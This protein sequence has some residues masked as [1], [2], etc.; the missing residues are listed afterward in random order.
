M[1]SQRL[2]VNDT[3]KNG[4]LIVSLSLLSHVSSFT[5]DHWTKV[6]SRS[7][8]HKMNLN[9]NEGKSGIFDM[10]RNFDDVMED[11]FFKRMGNGE[12]FYGK[13]KYNPSG[14]VEGKYN[15]MGL[16]DKTKIDMTREWKEEMMERKRL[17]RSE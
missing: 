5:T 2:P 6:Y 17:K 15:G 1:G 10:L 4:L 14:Q 11:F 9:D 7:I 13:R 8:T 16:S 3:M 12:I